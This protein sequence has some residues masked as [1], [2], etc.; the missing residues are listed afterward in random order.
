M[1]KLKNAVV[2]IDMLEDFVYGASHERRCVCE[3]LFDCGPGGL[4]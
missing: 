1:E 4:R 3:E 2:V